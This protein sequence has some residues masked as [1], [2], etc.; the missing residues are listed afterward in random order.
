MPRG[1]IYLIDV[2]DCLQEP[3]DQEYRYIELRVATNH[4]HPTH[5]CIYRF[6]VHGKPTGATVPCNEL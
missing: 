3:N 6:R 5:T 4:G 2:S 1:I